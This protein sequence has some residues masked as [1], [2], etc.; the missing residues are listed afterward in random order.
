MEQ[1][2]NSEERKMTF[3]VTQIQVGGKGISWIQHQRG[4]RPLRLYRLPA[5]GF[6]SVAG[7]DRDTLGRLLNEIQPK[8]QDQETTLAKGTWWKPSLHQD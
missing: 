5:L 2:P 1:A 6:G 4:F 3:P 7:D 8:Q